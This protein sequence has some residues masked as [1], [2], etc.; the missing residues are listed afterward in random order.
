MNEWAKMAYDQ[1]WLDQQPSYVWEVVNALKQQLTLENEM[2][3]YYMMITVKEDR[4]G[5]LHLAPV[6]DKHSQELIAMHN[7]AKVFAQ[8]GMQFQSEIVERLPKNAIKN[9]QGSWTAT[10]RVPIDL[11]YHWVE[12]CAWS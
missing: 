8:E 7:Q 4:M 2:K 3:G 1:E 10:T 6:S 12:F 5:N 11:F 9:M